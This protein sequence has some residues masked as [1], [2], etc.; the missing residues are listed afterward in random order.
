M[1]FRSNYVSDSKNW[2][3]INPWKNE[4]VKFKLFQKIDDETLLKNIV[5]NEVNSEIKLTFKDTLSKKT[6][7][8]WSTQGTLSF[9]DKFLS[10]I[11]KASNN[12]F[13]E[14]FENGLAALNKILTTEINTFNIKIDGFVNRDTI[15]YI[16]K[17]LV[18]KVD[19]LPNKIKNI[20][21]KLEQ[22]LVTTSTQKN[23][24]PFLVYHARDTLTNIVKISVAIPTKIKIFTDR[25]S[26]V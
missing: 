24:S 23:G 20:L 6:I 11:N 7:V 21:P 1:L 10:I 8:S 12:N 19:E 9:R 2:E 18:C 22:L 4:K 14:K 26:V 5:I 17:A 15:F 25:K 13:D 16:Q 3:T